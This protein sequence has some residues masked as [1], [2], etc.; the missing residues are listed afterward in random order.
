MLWVIDFDSAPVRIFNVLIPKISAKSIAHAIDKP[1]NV[2]LY[3][4]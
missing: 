3:S 2:R 1:S 4:R